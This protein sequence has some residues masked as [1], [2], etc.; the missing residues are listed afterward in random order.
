MIHKLILYGAGKR[1]RTLCKIL[2]WSDIFIE[3][4]IDSDK[5]KW[6]QEVD[7]RLIQP[8]K[9]MEILENVYICITM[10]D[11]KAIEQIRRQYK[12]VFI[13]N[14]IKEIGYYELILKVYKQNSNI[15]GFIKEYTIDTQKEEAVLFDCYQGLVLG[16]VESWTADICKALLSRGR[17]STYIISDG[18]TYDVE[19]ELLGH[20]IDVDIDHDMNFL[21]SSILELI[22]A[23]LLKLPCKVVTCSTDEV[24]LAAYMIKCVYPDQITVIS[25]IHNSCKMVYDAY[26]AFR[27]C[28]DIYIGVSQDIRNDMIQDGVAP[29]RIYSMTCPFSCE[30]KLIRGYTEDHEQPIHIGYAGRMD[31]WSGSGHSQKRMDLLLKC[32]GILEQRKVDFMMELAGDG[33]GKPQMEKYVR[34]HNLSERVRF[35]GRVKRTEIPSFWRRQDLCINLADYEG[36]SISI[37]EA[38]GNGAVPVVTETS[39]TKEDIA[40]G[41]NGYRI[42]V[43]DYAAA[44]GRIEYLAGH[45][46]YLHTMGEAAHAA[47]Y[48]KSLMEPHTDFWEKLLFPSN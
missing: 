23:I 31:S 10:M 2:K 3:A 42:P 20:I 36:R 14:S 30:E 44:A 22:E 43:G 25:V 40:D 32:I 6:G 41:V 16:G 7:G 4:V 24:M 8:P 18:G 5:Q 9:E 29:E 21:P 27:E 48:P 46:D 28:T 35:L 33:P 17:N 39:G 19:E 15:R 34:E 13:K 37:I 1:C 45:R 26:R 12:G 38:M 11:D 47:V